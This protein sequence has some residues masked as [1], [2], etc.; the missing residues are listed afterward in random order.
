MSEAVSPM[1]RS[2]VVRVS[3]GVAAAMAA[4]MLGTAQAGPKEDFFKAVELDRPQFVRSVIEAG[5]D[6]NTADD[7]G[8]T[9]LGIAMREGCFAAAEA[10]LAFKQVQIDLP[11]AAGETPLMMAA[12]R[13]HEAWV[14]RLLERGAAV[15]RPGWSPLHYAAS[16]PEPKVIEL[17]L[18]RGALIDA[19]SPNGSTPL[20]MAAGYGAVDGAALLLA[21]GADARPRNRAGLD[22]AD[23]ARRAGRDALAARIGAGVR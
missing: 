16:G 6:P 22:A 23:F 7:R 5:F 21:R 20:M 11:N 3:V 8:Q 17:L 13:G 15:N 9:G 19:P 4:V 14:R 12:L 10:L 2:V 18:A 1:R